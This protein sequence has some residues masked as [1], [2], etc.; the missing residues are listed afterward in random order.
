M[1]TKAESEALQ[2][3]ERALREAETKVSGLKD[4]VER[5][6]KSEEKNFGSFYHL[7]NRCVEQKIEKYTY[8]VCLFDRAFQKESYETSLGRF[9][10]AAFEEVLGAGSEV[11]RVAFTNGAKC[12]NGPSRSMTV[13][14]ECGQEEELKQVEE[15]SR[16]EYTGVLVTPA[17]CSEATVRDLE[18][19]LA[20]LDAEL[21]VLAD[22]HDEL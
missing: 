2:K 14:V 6:R 13:K 17:A 11:S 18:E 3:A 7:R 20:R 9:D 22:S 5:I 19:Q 10:T 1:D 4:D 16:C 21:Q 8:G 12:W 15:P